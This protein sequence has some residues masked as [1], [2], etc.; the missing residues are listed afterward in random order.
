MCGCFGDQISKRQKAVLVRSRENK[1]EVEKERL[2]VRKWRKSR[3]ELQR[4]AVSSRKQ[5]DGEN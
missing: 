3:G 4:D 5:K 1:W 2:V